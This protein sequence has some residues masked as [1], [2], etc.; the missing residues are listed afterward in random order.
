MHQSRARSSTTRP[1]R[2]TCCKSSAICRTSRSSTRS[3]AKSTRLNP[4]LL[5]TVRPS[6]LGPVPGAERRG[7]LRKL[8]TSS[9]TWSA[10]I[11]RVAAVMRSLSQ[12]P[13]P[14]TARRLASLCSRATM[15]SPSR[16][17]N[18][19]C[20]SRITGCWAAWLLTAVLLLVGQTVR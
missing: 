3:I 17:L 2:L 10:L 6:A 4:R 9:S 16:I 18:S 1:R 15:R 8:R 13:A 14:S 20:T 7:A 19:R 12:R 5:V 11:Y